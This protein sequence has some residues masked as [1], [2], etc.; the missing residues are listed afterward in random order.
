[1]IKENPVPV[2]PKVNL[3]IR[4]QAQILQQIQKYQKQD[5]GRR[6]HIAIGHI[7]GEFD[8]KEKKTRYKFIFIVL[9]FQIHFICVQ[10]ITNNSK[11]NPQMS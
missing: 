3:T 6:R 9:D 7:F 8:K 4:Q 10:I 11:V 2:H 1:M 5:K